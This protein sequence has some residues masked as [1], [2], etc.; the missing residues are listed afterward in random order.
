MCL[1][2]LYTKQTVELKCY[3]TVMKAQKVTSLIPKMF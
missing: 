3:L 1:I 2:K